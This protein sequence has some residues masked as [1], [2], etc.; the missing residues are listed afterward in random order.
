MRF[1]SAKSWKGFW[2]SAGII[3]SGWIL[4]TA[5]TFD[6]PHMDGSRRYGFP[7]PFGSEGGMCVGI[8]YCPLK[9][10]YSILMFDVLVAFCIIGSRIPFHK[11]RLRKK[12]KILP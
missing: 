3:L 5:L 7:I 12:G 2:I 11:I 8:G 6:S 4:V 1:L 10:N 9:I